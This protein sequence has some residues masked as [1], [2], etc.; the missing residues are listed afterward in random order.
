M[1]Q[2]MD[3]SVSPAQQDSW[4]GRTVG[5]EELTILQGRDCW[6][7]GVIWGPGSWTGGREPQECADKISVR[8]V[9]AT[10]PQSFL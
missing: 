3:S 8:S 7:R 5:T 1:H 9:V 6:P 10:G 4:P 2:D